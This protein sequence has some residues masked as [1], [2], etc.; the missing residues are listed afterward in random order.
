MDEA[1]LANSIDLINVL[2]VKECLTYRNSTWNAIVDWFDEVLGAKVDNLDLVANY[3]DKEFQKYSNEVNIDEFTLKSRSAKF[4]KLLMILADT[5]ADEKILK[6]TLDSLLDRLY[7]CN[8][9][10]YIASEKVE[11]CLLILNNML[12]YINGDYN[13]YVSTYQRVLCHSKLLFS[14]Q[15]TPSLWIPRPSLL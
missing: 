6:K 15:K 7:S 9:Y 8:K 4:A 14:R 2:S 1:Y 13:L 12:A 10:V 11:K 3:I 5:K